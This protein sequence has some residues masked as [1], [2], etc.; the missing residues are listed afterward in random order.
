LNTRN[1]LRC[2]RMNNPSVNCVIC[3]HDHEEAI[4]HIFFECEFSEPCWSTLHIVWDLSLS[5]IVSHFNYSCYME[6]TILATW[7]IRIHRNGIIFNGEQ[8]SL[9]RWKK[10]FKELILL[11]KHK[12]KPSLELSLHTWLTYL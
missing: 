4:Q 3:S 8:T 1:L 12:A 5:V 10:D 6:V 9:P 7:A 11:C 2:R